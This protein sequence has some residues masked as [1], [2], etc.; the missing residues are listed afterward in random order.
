[1]GVA[2]RFG[3]LGAIA[4]WADGVPV[5]VGHARQRWVLGALLADADGAVPA[6]VLVDRV[7]GADAPDRGRQALYGYVSRLRQVLSG[8]EADMVR[9]QGGYRLKV[10]AGSVD[11]HRFRGL[12]DQARAMPDPEK[13]ASVWEEALGLW[14]G[15]A[16]TGVDT[17]WFNAQRDF[18]DRERLAAQLDL[19]DVRLRLGQHDQVLAELFARAEAHPLDERMAGQLILALYRGGRSADALTH[20]Q[21]IRRRL[22]EELGTDPGPALRQL[23][24][25]LLTADPALITPAPRS[26]TGTGPASASVPRQL[27]APPPF[28]I[29][30]E[31]ELARLDRLLESQAERGG[32]VVISAIGGTG[33]IGKTWLA[34]RWAHEQ[35]ERFPDGQ[36]YA[37]LRGFSPAEDPVPPEAALRMFL[38]AL[39]AAPAQ[40]PAHLDA[41]AA[42]YR[43]LVADRRL[44]IV[45][46]NA[47]DT[48][49]V[50]PLVPG[51]PHCTVV[52]TSRHQLG[53][54]ITA[55]GGTPS[56]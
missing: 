23:H 35:R 50:L 16:Y 49:Q 41:Q 9:D 1:M 47:R 10:S 37:D 8:V 18:L 7:W 27:P 31:R 6:D 12:A 26:T 30:R 32:T 17:P 19:A 42:L 14:R 33:G 11:V 4:V 46:D 28:F 36:L 54:L 34:L 40:I 15:S 25:Q 39:G 5:D 45:L 38:D 55:H 21:D 48:A 3:V 29:G 22:A 43:T 13:A 56:P 51:S 53:G 2:V 44:L 20:Y 52:V 24:Q